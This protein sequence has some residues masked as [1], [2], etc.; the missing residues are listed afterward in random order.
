[1]SESQTV[2]KRDILTPA[3]VADWLGVTVQTL[4][5]WRY[6]KTGPSFTKLGRMIR[7]ERSSVE[8]FIAAGRVQTA[9]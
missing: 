5:G 9:A 1:M 7:Y 8:K 2:A 6:T 3:E 4:N